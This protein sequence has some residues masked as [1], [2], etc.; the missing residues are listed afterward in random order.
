MLV[1]SVL[2]TKSEYHEKISTTLHTIIILP[3]KWKK[4]GGKHHG[5]TGRP[6]FAGRKQLT[7]LG[8]N[9]QLSEKISHSQRKNLNLIHYYPMTSLAD[10]MIPTI[11]FII[12][13]HSFIHVCEYIYVSSI[14]KLSFQKGI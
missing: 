7:K 14:H 3:L 1:T 10:E 13:I 5:L 11:L 2:L 4:L 8:G 9:G 12:I 6:C